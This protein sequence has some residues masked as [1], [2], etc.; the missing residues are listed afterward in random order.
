MGISEACIHEMDSVTEPEYETRELGI[1]LRI[2][3][4]VQKHTC[5]K[6]GE[7][8]HSIPF[9]DRLIAAAAVG[10]CKIALKLAGE[11]VRFIRK[12]LSESSKDMAESLGVAAETFSRWENDKSPIGPS[13]ERLFRLLTWIKLGE[14]APAI[15]FKPT[16]IVNMKIKAIR[17]KDD[18]VPMCFELIRFK[19][20][21]EKPT[22]DA[23]SEGERKAA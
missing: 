10:R 12:A 20:T 16:D 19:V 11:E 14:L 13:Y 2:F 23:Y 3:N 4:S 17:S 1:P 7:I 9:P 5:K 6:C 21:A 8:T 15:D 18:E 22:T